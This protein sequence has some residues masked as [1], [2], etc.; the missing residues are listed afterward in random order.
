MEEI[1]ALTLICMLLAGVA[2]RVRAA[3]SDDLWLD[4]VWIIFL[5]RAVHL[6][7]HRTVKVART[8]EVICF[9]TV[10]VSYIP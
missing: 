7:A 8:T 3:G 5:A 9:S 6:H 4:E 2:E 1:Y 10:E